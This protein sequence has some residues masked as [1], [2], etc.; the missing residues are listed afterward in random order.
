MS[1]GE[2]EVANQSSPQ[3]VSPI[4][5]SIKH[6]CPRQPQPFTYCELVIDLL[7]FQ[8]PGIDIRPRLP[9]EVIPQLLVIQ[10]S[11]NISVVEVKVSSEFGFK[12]SAN[13]DQLA[14]NVLRLFSDKVGKGS[15]LCKF[16]LLPDRHGSLEGLGVNEV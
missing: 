13:L 6:R 4:V 12:S 16:L 15:C 9:D 14:V 7:L 2:N 3:K 8:L 5:I 11:A 10:P 1:N